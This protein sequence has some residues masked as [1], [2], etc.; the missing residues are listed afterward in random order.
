MS[1]YYMS[2]TFASRTEATICYLAPQLLIKMLNQSEA[3]VLCIR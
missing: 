2:D 1:K 3:G